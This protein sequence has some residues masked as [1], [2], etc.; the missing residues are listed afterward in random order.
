MTPALRA[1]INQESNR[2]TGYN[3]ST[4]RKVDEW[5]S[6]L[7]KSMEG[8]K[9]Y[10][11]FVKYYKRVSTYLDKPNTIPPPKDA[12]FPTTS[13]EAIKTLADH[14]V[15]TRR[16]F[17]KLFKEK[18]GFDYYVFLTDSQKRAHVLSIS[19]E[20]LGPNCYGHPELD[21]GNKFIIAWYEELKTENARSF[22]D[23][24]ST[25]NF[26]SAVKAQDT[27][28]GVS[29]TAVGTQVT[30]V[31]GDMTD[32]GSQGAVTG[33][34]H[35]IPTD[36]NA[37]ESVV[38][39]TP[40]TANGAPPS[41]MTTTDAFP[42]PHG[43]FKNND[44]LENWYWDQASI[45]I[46]GQHDHHGDSSI[47]VYPVPNSENADPSLLDGTHVPSDNGSNF[48]EH[49]GHQVDD[50]P[51]MH[52]IPAAEQSVWDHQWQDREDFYASRRIPGEV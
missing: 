33:N 38:A 3:E 45:R 35:T 42:Q 36:T 10:D 20:P 25:Y 52:T 15:G 47:V 23:F 8:M 22:A 44:E 4:R 16:L 18:Y 19:P 13:R 50:Y 43:V 7:M 49:G 17:W 40:G 9:N 39:S 37:T 32:G 28:N 1:Q 51:D 14:Q 29:L 46:I 6:K 30:T 31:P 34:D 11:S 5:S 2:G 12:N 26:P 27:F 41:V 48:H 21:E 24:F